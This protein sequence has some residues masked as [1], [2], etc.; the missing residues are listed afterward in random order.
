MNFK[1]GRGSRRSIALLAAISAFF[2]PNAAD[3]VDVPSPSNYG[4]AGLLDTRTARFFPDGYLNVTTSFTAPDDRY[5]LTFQALPWA[6]LTFRYTITHGLFDSGIPLHDRSF[7]LKFRLSRETEDLPQLA[8]GLQDF[9]GTGVYSG[10]YLVASKRL[11]AFDFSF[12]MGWGRLGSRGTFKNP[13]GLAFRSFLDRGNSVG[14]GGAL[15]FSSYFHGPEVGLFGGIEYDTPIDNVKLKVEY[16]SDAYTEEKIER[17]KDYGF[18]VNAGISYRPFDWLDFGLSVMHGRFLGL[19]IS[20]LMDPTSNTWL[21]R[22]DPAP[23]FRARPAQAAATILQPDPPAGDKAPAHVTRYVDLTRATPTP[24]NNAQD[25]GFPAIA[26]SLPPIA[27][28]ALPAPAAEPAHPG[29]F[30]P[31][32]QQRIISGLENQKLKVMGLNVQ[33]DRLIVLI[34]NPRYRRDTEAVARTA[35][36]LSATAPAEINYFEITFLIAGQPTATVTLPRA[37]IDALARREGSPAELFQATDIGPGQFAP[38]DHLSPDLFPQLNTFLFPVLQESLF[39]PNNPIYVRLGVGAGGEV[40]LTRGWSLDASLVATI[41]DNFNQINRPSNSVLPH[42]RSDIAEYLKQGRY[43]IANLSTSYFFKLAPEL[44]GRVTGGI[45]EQM[46]DGVG[47]ELL[48]RPFDARWA[49]AVDAWEVRQ[50]GFND[51]LDI[52]KYQVF[53]GHVTAYYQLP[54]HDVGVSVSL[55]QYLAGDRGATFQFWRTFSTGVQIGAWFTLTN[56]SAARFGEGSFDKGIYIIIPLEWAAPFASRSSYDLSLRPIQRDGGQ[57]LLGDTVL[58]D[59]TTGSNYGAFAGEWN[60][61][62]R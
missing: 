53:T 4:G 17:G 29:E 14:S 28:P 22:I 46:F 44:Y 6:E 42:V 16:S 13:F 7:D 38:L 61:L 55:G 62:I 21:A 20:A 36:V 11:G 48:Y 51:L 57:R 43:G 49:V 9:I 25:L 30:A 23:R 19:R 37:Q 10:E 34:E 8:L 41:W 56:V 3:A 24:N 45:L 31:E 60:R 58:Y 47:G 35:R 2:I 12:G 15:S 54:W 27:A 33:K 50:R 39:D 32:V 18:P 59:M 26:P 40:R 1:P 52:R 5:S